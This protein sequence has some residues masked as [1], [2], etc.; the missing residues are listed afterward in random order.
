MA[1]TVYWKQEVAP[2]LGEGS[3]LAI[4]DGFQRFV[5]APGVCSEISKNLSQ[6]LQ[7]QKT[8]P[9]DTHPPLRDRIAAA[10]NVPETFT[11][12]D[13]EPASSLLDN[14]PAT[15]LRFVETCVPDIR[16]GSLTHVAWDDV[17]NQVTIPCW[18]RFVNEYSEPLQGVTAG[19]VPDRVSKFPE[20]GS[21]IRDPK[22]MLLSPPQ[23]TAR[24]GRLFASALALAMIRSGWELRVQPAVFR[25]CRGDQE[26]NPFDAINKLMAGK[27]SHQDW[28]TRCHE[29]GISELVLLRDPKP[30]AQIAAQG[31]L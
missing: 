27:L 24:A 30:S 11:T 4:G 8:Q 2:W 9:Y 13:T 16:P 1:W 26:F 12:E 31:T 20:I 22:G 15:E 19:L 23:R 18:Q 10:R 7:E 28:Q 14:L 6:R 5:A 17:A 29:L 25:M 21:R 3:L